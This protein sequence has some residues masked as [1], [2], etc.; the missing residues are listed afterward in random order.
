MTYFKAY[1]VVSWE[2]I[3]ITTT[4]FGTERKCKLVYEDGSEETR[5][6]R[7][8]SYYGLKK[9]FEIWK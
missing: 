4:S 2:V 3:D 7:E 8:T 6:L 1:K 9:D 5:W